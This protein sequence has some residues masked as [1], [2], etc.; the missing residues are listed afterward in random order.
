MAV[1]VDDM[2]AQYGQLIMC[3]MLSDTDDE[4]HEMAAR[5]GIAR[6][7]WQSP[8]KTSTSHYDICLTKRA[9]A[10]QY[11]AI[12]VTQRQMASMS[13]RRR[14]T[15]VMG[16][17][18]DAEAWLKSHFTSKRTIQIQTTTSIAMTIESDSSY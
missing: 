2:R 4:L 7:W 18:H 8:A 5:I 10:V 17:P 14:V 16:S 6:K 1:Y 3:H 15:G 13:V 12:E 9:L 11:G